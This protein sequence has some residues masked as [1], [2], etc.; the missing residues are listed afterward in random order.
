M[1]L[2][3]YEGRGNPFYTLRDGPYMRERVLQ[4]MPSATVR[5][6]TSRVNLGACL[7]VPWLLLIGHML[8]YSS[9]DASSHPSVVQVLVACSRPCRHT[10]Q[11]PQNMFSIRLRF[12]YSTTLSSVNVLMS[13]FSMCEH[14]LSVSY[15]PFRYM[16]GHFVVVTLLLLYTWRGHGLV[17][18]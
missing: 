6:G 13:P 11:V 8:S 1:C 18:T 15:C 3:A 2:C 5:S 17:A 14:A 10:R 16:G 4:P 9:H 12:M 7:L